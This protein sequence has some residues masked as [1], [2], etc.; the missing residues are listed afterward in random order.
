MFRPEGCVG[1]A[2]QQHWTRAVCELEPASAAGTKFY[3]T[4]QCCHEKPHFLFSS[5][6]FF[7]K[8]YHS[9][10][11]TVS[12]KG[13]DE[14]TCGVSASL[15]RC[16]LGFCWLSQGRGRALAPVWLAG[17]Q[18]PC[19]SPQ[20][21][22][23]ANLST[24]GCFHGDHSWAGLHGYSGTLT[25]GWRADDD[26]WVYPAVPGQAGWGAAG[27]GP[28]GWGQQ[29]VG[30]IRSWATAGGQFV[31]AASLRVQS[32]SSWLSLRPAVSLLGQGLTPSPIN[33]LAPNIS[34]CIVVCPA[35]AG[36]VSHHRA[37]G[38]V[39]RRAG[40]LRSKTT[41]KCRRQVLYFS[42][43]HAMWTCICSTWSSP[44]PWVLLHRNCEK[45]GCSQPPMHRCLNAKCNVLKWA[46]PDGQGWLSISR[47]AQMG[48]V[49]HENKEVFI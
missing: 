12:H 30:D 35:A 38:N 17:G 1:L 6:G 41:H 45:R 47:K 25:V 33:H 20:C 2:R 4:T 15:L 26:G 16:L 46:N 48:K 29:Q 14:E 36:A 49:R 24:A 44:D 23:I 11:K 19:R 7:G 42:S 39:P 31:T 9:W 27:H 28:A 13:K 32:I 5:W 40:K 8:F 34:L 10:W 18:P 37:G 43:A 3:G 21:L 22:S